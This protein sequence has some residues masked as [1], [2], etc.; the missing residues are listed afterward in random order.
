MKLVIGLLAGLAVTLAGLVF[1]VLCVIAAMPWLS[2]G[3]D[4]GPPSNAEVSI[5]AAALPAPVVDPPAAPVP[6]V[7]DATPGGIVQA[8]I[9]AA[10]T[11]LGTPYQWGGCTHRGID[12]SCFVMTVLAAV[13]IH[14]PRTT[15]PQLAWTSPVSAADARAGDLVFFD[16]TCS[17]CGANPTHVG[18][19]LGGG[20][21]VDC[22]DPCRVEAVYGGHNARYGRVPG[23]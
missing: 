4:G 19:F 7:V 18:L 20:R 16:N 6:T 15:V 8:A 14:A 1:M 11:W 23:L 21:M 5:P 22:G 3:L 9:A 2:T 12:C 13:G 17:D 10:M